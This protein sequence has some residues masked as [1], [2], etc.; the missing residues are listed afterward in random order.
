MGEPLAGSNFRRFRPAQEIDPAT[1][2]RAVMRRLDGCLRE[3]SAIDVLEVMDAL[4]VT[5]MPLVDDFSSGNA[6]AAISRSDV[7]MLV[8]RFGHKARII[9]ARPILLP[10]VPADIPVGQVPSIAGPASA[11]IVLERGGRLAGIYEPSS[12]WGI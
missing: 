2:V 3:N 11:Y 10:G 12:P 9:Q 1:P 5:F 6:R 8:E 4:G 7:A